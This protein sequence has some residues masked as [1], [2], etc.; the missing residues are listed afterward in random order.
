MGGGEALGLQVGEGVVCGAC[1]RA[2]AW[3]SSVAGPRVVPAGNRDRRDSAG[4]IDAS[5]G[6]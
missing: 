6:R 4:K 3:A 1:P 5:A 2:P